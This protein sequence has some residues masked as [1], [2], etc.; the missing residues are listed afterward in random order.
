MI[1]FIFEPSC[2]DEEQQKLKDSFLGYL[3]S[4]KEEFEKE[5]VVVT[6]NPKADTFNSRY[7][8]STTKNKEI[9]VGD[10]LARFQKYQREHS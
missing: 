6:V 2:A 9:G 1:D 10:L 5:G 4:F 7:S 3:G 8:I